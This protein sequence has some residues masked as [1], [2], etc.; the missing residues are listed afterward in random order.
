MAAVRNAAGGGPHCGGTDLL[1]LLVLAQIPTT[2]CSSGGLASL[3]PDGD[4]L[5]AG[6][7]VA[8]WAK[9]SESARSLAII[10]HGDD[11][12]SIVLYTVTVTQ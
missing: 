2:A 4:Q 7:L 9:G 6:R 11:G 10:S 12:I 5:A 1:P 3:H 8:A